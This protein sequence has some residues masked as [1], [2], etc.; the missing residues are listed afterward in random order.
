MKKK[1]TK[2]KKPV[3]QKIDVVLES[4]LNLEQRVKELI[5]KVKDLE[6][7]RYYHPYNAEPKK[8]WPNDFYRYDDVTWTFHN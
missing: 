4:L 5:D 1:T 8:Y 3:K 6:T 7:Q 2:K